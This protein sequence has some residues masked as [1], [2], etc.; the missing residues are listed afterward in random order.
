MNLHAELETLDESTREWRIKGMN[1]SPEERAEF[2]RSCFHAARLNM[3]VL[4]LATP[5]LQPYKAQREVFDELVPKVLENVAEQGHDS[6]F[7][8]EQ[9]ELY[10]DA[11]KRAYRALA[12]EFGFE[13]MTGADIESLGNF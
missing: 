2:L 6:G 9:V 4:L 5:I 7:T 8:D 11:H 10:V 1:G 13:T 3:R 12:G